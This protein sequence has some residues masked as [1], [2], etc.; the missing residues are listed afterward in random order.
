[1]QEG[2][3]LLGIPL[4]CLGELPAARIHLERGDNLSWRAILLWHL[5]YLDQAQQ[6]MHGALA[7]QLPNVW[8]RAFVLM[9]A[10]TLSQ[11]R[12]DWPVA[13]QR[14][15]NLMKLATEH[16]LP[17]LGAQGSLLHGR[18]L[19]ALG[20]EAEGIEQITRGLAAYLATGAEAWRPMY[21]GML[22]ASYAHAGQATE[23]LRQVNKALQIVEATQERWWEPEL[24]RLRGVLLLEVSSDHHAE[25][26]SS[27]HQ[28]ITIARRQHAKSWELRAA[29]SLAR[30]WQQQGKQARARKLLA[31]VYDGFTEGFGTADLQAAKTL[32]EGLS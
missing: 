24:Y 13:Q 21:L 27:F 15:D 5:G 11:L 17:L 10:S 18:A 6:T 7:K 8:Q 22:A 9:A 31:G 20:Q 26:V 16:D 4:F 25:T 12:R 32:L 3:A 28:A 14:A 30:L 2:H 23:G 29:M 19:V 1:M